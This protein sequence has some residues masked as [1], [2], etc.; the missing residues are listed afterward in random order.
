M[1][2][3]CCFCGGKA[4]YRNKRTD[5]LLCRRC[6]K[7]F[8][9]LHGLDPQHLRLLARENL[10]LHHEVVTKRLVPCRL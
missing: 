9:L 4:I 7:D 1:S 5:E 10:E 6:A 2:E 3:T 8:V